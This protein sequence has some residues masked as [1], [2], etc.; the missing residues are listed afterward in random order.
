MTKKTRLIPFEYKIHLDHSKI[1]FDEKTFLH[2]YYEVVKLYKFDHQGEYL[3]LYKYK[4]C[5]AD[6][7]YLYG[8]KKVTLFEL[9]IAQELEE[10]T[11]YMNV[12]PN[13]YGNHYESLE[14]AQRGNHGIEFKGTLKVT[15]TDEDL[16]K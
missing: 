4:T 13:L 3:A 10:K 8:T 14:E 12:Y 11:F 5:H 15:Y 9:F 2:K 7:E 6:I 1:R 16:I